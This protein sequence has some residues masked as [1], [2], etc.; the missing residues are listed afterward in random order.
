MNIQFWVFVIENEATRFK[1]FRKHCLNRIST[2]D[3]FTSFGAYMQTHEGPF[4]FP[5]SFTLSSFL[6]WQPLG[7]CCM[8][9]VT[10]RIPSVS[11]G[12]TSGLTGQRHSISKPHIA[13]IRQH[14]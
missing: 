13:V 10:A 3:Y 11:M 4:P 7:T 9:A 5:L 12:A 14:C 2:N 6:L 1:Y 8:Q